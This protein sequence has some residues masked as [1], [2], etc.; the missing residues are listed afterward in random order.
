MLSDIYVASFF[1]NHRPLSVT[2]SVPLST[3]GEVFQSIFTPKKPSSKSNPGTAEVIYT[4]ASVVQ[5]LDGNIAQSQN[6]QQHQNQQSGQQDRPNLISALTQHNNSNASNFSE[7]QHID[8]SPQQSISSR[9]P[10]GVKLAIQQIA[11]Q[12]RPFN[13]PPVPQP[14][15]DAQI[16]AK[17]AEQAAAA[18][19]AEEEQAR[20]LEQQI[21]RQDTTQGPR[22]LVINVHD[23]ARERQ[24]NRF[25][26]PHTTRI[27]QPLYPQL[28]AEIE[29]G[30]DGRTRYDP[31]A[32][33]MNPE[34]RRRVGRIRQGPQEKSVALRRGKKMYAISV[35]R[36]RK[37]K[38]KKH[39]FKKLMRRT[40][41]LRRKLD[42]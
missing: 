29:E 1:S 5:N 9:V 39:K 31:N 16:E 35:R 14:I 28:L 38:M 40:R 26:T 3:R 7:P 37:L 42:K 2:S 6:Q 25:F 17:A 30:V 34:P 27:E 4:L 21:E 8:G 22:H 32:S 12:F 11:R 19:E 41:T 15:S 23:R 20:Q 13:P 33:I 36:Q 24:A 10:N 18:E